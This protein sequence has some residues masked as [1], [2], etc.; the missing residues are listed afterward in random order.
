MVVN[1]WDRNLEFYQKCGFMIA[2]KR[3][4]VSRGI[5]ESMATQNALDQV[6]G[7]ARNVLSIA[8]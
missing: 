6:A 4:A 3:I 8:M 7:I 1:L 5:R 2:W